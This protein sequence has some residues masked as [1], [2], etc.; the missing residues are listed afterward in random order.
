[1]A[2]QY[3]TLTKDERVL[4]I[5]LNR[6][7]TN[8]LSSEFGKELFNAFS[9]A[10]RMDDVTVVVITSALEKAFIAGADIKEMAAM[11]QAESEAFSKLLQD[12]NTILERMKKVVIA[13]I[14]GHAL[15]G[16]C[17][18]AMACDYRFM[19]AGKAL[20][21]LPEAGLGIVPGAGGTQR[22]PRL[23]GLAK[24]KDILLWGKVM[25]GEEALAIG[26]VDRI[27]PAESFMAEV[28]EFARR[29]ASGAGKA[30]GY[31]KAAVNEGIELPMEEA[32]AV[33][34]KHGLE[35]LL[36]HDARE[37]LTAFGEKRKPNFLSR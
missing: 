33:E 9:E 13:A 22:L 14:N 27:I 25:G 16:G 19:A 32:L 28:M 1:M 21:G 11:G 15:G 3:I 36:T 35:N 7:P 17:E 12:A 4:T 8:P 30:L 26:L 23:V 34:R 24:A 18:L 10:E 2:Y 29:L 20:I 31:I 5:S 37:G 6:P